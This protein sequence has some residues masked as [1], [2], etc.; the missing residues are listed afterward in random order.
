LEQDIILDLPQV[1][2]EAVDD[3]EEAMTLINKLFQ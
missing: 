1:L 3:N 2:L